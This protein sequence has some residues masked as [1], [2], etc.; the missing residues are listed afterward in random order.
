M[1]QLQGLSG[2]SDNEC[3]GLVFR[4]NV[5]LCYTNNDSILERRELRLLK[6][7]SCPGCEKCGWMRDYLKEDL[8]MDMYDTLLGEIEHGKLYTIHYTWYRDWETGIYDD[9][10][11]EVIEYKEDI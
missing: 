2:Q 7:K 3:N 5:S 6:R 4:G 9:Y 8:S 11:F 10:D 1:L